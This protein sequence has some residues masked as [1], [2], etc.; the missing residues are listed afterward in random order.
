MS[1]RNKEFEFI[2]WLRLD[3]FFSFIFL[4]AKL[5][6]ISRELMRFNQLV[7]LEQWVFAVDVIKI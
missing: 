5:K 3:N 6:E 1:E 7:K 2:D 4:L